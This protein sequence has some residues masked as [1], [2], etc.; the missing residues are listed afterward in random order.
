MSGSTAILADEL[1]Q[2]DKIRSVVIPRVEFLSGQSP[3]DPLGIPS[4]TRN[5][6]SGYVFF[7]DFSEII[8]F[9]DRFRAP[10]NELG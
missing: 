4:I 6:R 7:C 2:G 9:L 1:L 5:L 8:I 3:S 10:E